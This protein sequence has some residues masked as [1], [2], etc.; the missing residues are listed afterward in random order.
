LTVPGEFPPKEGVMADVQRISVEEARRKVKANE[1]LLVCA[2]DDAE[3]YK[4]LNLEGSISFSSFQ[5]R[6]SSLPKNKE[7]IFYC[8]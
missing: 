1:A 7:I 2:Y 5:S 6:L 3:K 4:K 8:A